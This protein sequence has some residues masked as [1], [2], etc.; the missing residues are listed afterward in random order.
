[1]AVVRAVGSLCVVWHITSPA[2]A[3]ITI[4][5]VPGHDRSCPRI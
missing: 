1:M 2:E 5:I 4:G 3:P